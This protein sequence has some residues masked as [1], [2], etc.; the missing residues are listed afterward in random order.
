MLID[1]SEGLIAAS[2]DAGITPD[3][4]AYAWADFVIIDKRR[5]LMHW[6]SAHVKDDQDN[7]HVGTC[8]PD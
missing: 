2:G 4:E 5:G 6:S 7:V 1:N 8:Q 3:K